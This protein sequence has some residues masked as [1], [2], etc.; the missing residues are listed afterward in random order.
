[1]HWDLCILCVR[2]VSLSIYRC[3]YMCIYNRYIH[4]YIYRYIYR[5]RDI[6]RDIYVNTYLGSMVT[7]LLQVVPMN[8][9]P[10]LPK[11][12]QQ[13]QSQIN[14]I[15]TIKKEEKKSLKLEPSATSRKNSIRNIMNIF[16]AP[17]L[18]ITC[19]HL[20]RIL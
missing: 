8:N 13:H 4:R 5:Y 11:G 9:R 17:P 16:L 19:C 2:C 10:G 6:E 12:Q 1:M 15:N 18:A 7:T 20:D 3:V 14:F